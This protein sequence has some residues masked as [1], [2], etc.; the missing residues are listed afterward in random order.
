MV[1]SGSSCAANAPVKTASKLAPTSTTETEGG[2]VQSSPLKE[3]ADQLQ[4]AFDSPGA[5]P[6]PIRETDVVLRAHTKRLSM[7]I[8][9]TTYRGVICGF[10]FK[11]TQP[12]SPVTISMTGTKPDGSRFDSGPLEVTWMAGPNPTNRSVV[13]GT[14]SNADWSFNA[15]ATP[16]RNGAGWVVSL[17]GVT[18]E[19]SNVIP[20]EVVCALSSAS[21]F[22]IDS[23]PVGHWA[24]FATR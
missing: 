13:A 10:T 12:Q 9:D 1:F 7:R 18:P 19:G 4:I 21:E 8:I 6:R 5:D 11:G 14:S 2:P 20:K 22:A 17:G 23:G 16:N 15:D 24:G 3:T